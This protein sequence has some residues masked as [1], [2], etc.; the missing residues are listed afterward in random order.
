ME[1]LGTIKHKTSKNSAGH[2]II[3][4]PTFSTSVRFYE[5]LLLPHH[6]CLPQACYKK[7]LYFLVQRKNIPPRQDFAF[8]FSRKRI[9]DMEVDCILELKS[10]AMVGELTVEGEEP[11]T[12]AH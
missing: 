1:I 5:I 9:A 12:Q 2:H 11:V 3:S 6:L 8:L 7:A 4:H 10:E